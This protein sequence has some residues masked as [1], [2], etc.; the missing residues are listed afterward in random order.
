MF[1]CFILAPLTAV[2]RRVNNVLVR[3]TLLMTATQA[4]RLFLLFTPNSVNHEGIS[5]TALQMAYGYQAP[6][7]M[8]PPHA[9]HAIIW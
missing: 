4:S 1:I 5:R 2:H 6:W 7:D 8:P 3:S 9:G